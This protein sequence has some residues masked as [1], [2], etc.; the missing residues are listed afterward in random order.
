VLLLVFVGVYGQDETAAGAESEAAGGEAAEGA[1]GKSA[2][3][4]DEE[5]WNYVEFLKSEVK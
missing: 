5:A 3:E 2:E 1:E 4:G